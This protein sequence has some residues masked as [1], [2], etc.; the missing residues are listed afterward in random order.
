MIIAKMDGA[1]AA[2]TPD[3]LGRVNSQTQLS[4]INTESGRFAL[5]DSALGKLRPSPRPESLTDP[6]PLAPQ[7][8]TANSKTETPLRSVPLYA[9][10]DGIKR[11]F[12]WDGSRWQRGVRLELVGGS[13][14]TSLPPVLLASTTSASA[15]Q[16]Q[17]VVDG[18]SVPRFQ[19]QEAISKRYTEADLTKLGINASNTRIY[20][21]DDFVNADTYMGGGPK[22]VFATHGDVTAGIVSAALKG[23]GEV[24]R[25]NVAEKGKSSWNDQAFVKQINQIIAAEAKRQN[26]T[27]ATVDLSQVTISVSYKFSEAM[28]QMKDISAAVSAFTARG[29]HFFSAAGNGSYTAAGAALKNT[30]IVDGSSVR[31]GQ[32]IPTVQKPWSEYQNG[33]LDANG[34]DV[35]SQRA[36]DPSS[37]SIIAPSKLETRIEKGSIEFRDDSN[38][39]GWSKLVDASRTT[40]IPIPALATDGLVGLK[41]QK[42][43]TGKQLKD[44]Q[45]WKFKTHKE[46]IKNAQDKNAETSMD[47]TPAELS[48][49]DQKVAAERKRLIGDQ[50]LMTLNEYLKFTGSG[51]DSMLY[52][53]ALASIPKGTTQNQVLVS[54]ARVLDGDNKSPLQLQYFI[55][56]K[57]TGL[58][59]IQHNLL[60]AISNGTSWATPAAAASHAIWQ[61]EQVAAAKAATGR[62]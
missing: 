44:F 47:L 9:R 40:S 10:K 18:V 20:V 60:T 53:Q 31:I 32:N 61:R 55:L 24:T 58:Q 21:I 46:A 56:D 17:V 15:K 6:K 41:P 23:K 59:A 35:R 1:A 39:K 26:K 27:I 48:V 7:D 4:S 50:P 5:K 38:P 37:Q 22:A 62:Q 45:E 3:A 43:V 57:K 8:N 28:S 30:N 36:L 2:L 25:V 16:A 33:A 49:V 12:D 11:S 51:P 54:A 52:Q 13:S 19:P 14:T 29:G 42:F 34:N